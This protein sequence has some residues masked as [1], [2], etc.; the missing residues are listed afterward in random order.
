[1]KKGKLKMIKQEA[2][3]VSFFISM[4]L[5]FSCVKGDSAS[6]DVRSISGRRGLMLR[7]NPTTASEALAHMKF[8][9]KVVVISEKKETVYIANLPGH[10]CRITWKNKTGWAFSGYLTYKKKQQ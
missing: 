1:M 4:F 2:I 7:Q 10:W 8:G 3:I 9:D 6:R 5:L